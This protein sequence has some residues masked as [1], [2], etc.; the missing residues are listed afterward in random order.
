[1]CGT[2][3]SGNQDDADDSHDNYC[4]ETIQEPNFRLMSVPYGNLTRLAI[5]EKLTVSLK[6]EKQRSIVKHNSGIVDILP[7]DD[8][9]NW[10]QHFVERKIHNLLMT[11]ARGLQA[12]RPKTEYREPTF[13]KRQRSVKLELEHFIDADTK[14]ITIIK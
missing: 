4:N 10:Y 5:Q 12:L 9:E 3:G 1:M 6:R 8:L 13:K 11:I 7:Y 2:S 14:T